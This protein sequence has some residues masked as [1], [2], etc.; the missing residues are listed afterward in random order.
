MRFRNVF[1]EVVTRFLNNITRNSGRRGQLY[2]EI[3]MVTMT[4]L[5]QNRVYKSSSS[6]SYQSRGT[7]KIYIQNL[8]I[9]LLYFQIFRR[10]RKL[11]FFLTQ[12]FQQASLPV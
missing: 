7:C 2:I 9:K 3:L 1:L 11:F 8:H 5:R 12:T 10:A 4:L 6:S